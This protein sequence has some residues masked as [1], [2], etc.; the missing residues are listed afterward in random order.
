MRILGWFLIVLFILLI[1]SSEAAWIHPKE[2]FPDPT[3]ARLHSGK[4][5][6]NQ[7]EN[8]DLTRYGYTG[9]ELMTYVQA[10]KYAW[11]ACDHFIRIIHI[12]AHGMVHARMW[13]WKVKNY[14]ADYR[15]YIT[16]QGIKAGDVKSKFLVVYSDPP[17]MWGTGVLSYDY[18]TSKE[19][20]KTADWWIYKPDLRKVRRLPVPNDRGDNFAGSELTM[21][22]VMPWYEAWEEEHKIVGEDRIK[23]KE[24]WVIESK[25][26]NPYYYLSKRL[27]WIE[28]E[29]F[30]DLHEEQFNRKGEPWKVID[31]TW[32]QINPLNYWV[33]EEYN[34]KNVL[35][36]TRTILQRLDWDFDQGFKDGEFL[37]QEMIKQYQWKYPK[38]I[39]AIKSTGDVSP[40][41]E[42]REKVWAQRPSDN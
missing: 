37:P 19:F 29:N 22:D 36:R 20:P 23:D 39:P 38:N 8:E 34:C 24:C 6:L 30:L 9:L 42:P 1:S 17:W 15:A 28:K 25:N 35:T 4:T 31:K 16:H 33:Q 41:P 40:P 12:G 18:M 14:F 21:D 3:I 2:L 32:R 10:N 5:S 27:T 13:L 26:H 11:R 7:G